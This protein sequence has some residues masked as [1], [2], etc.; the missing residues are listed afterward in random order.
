MEHVSARVV[1]C[2]PGQTCLSAGHAGYF[3]TRNL[4]QNWKLR[5]GLND[6]VS[7]GQKSPAMVP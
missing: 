3:L 7:D 2:I 4:A 5:R 1:L 6:L